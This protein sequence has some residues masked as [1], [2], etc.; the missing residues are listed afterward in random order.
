MHNH[1]SQQKSRLV[2]LGS[3]LLGASV[4]VLYAVIS[5]MNSYPLRSGRL[6]QQLITDNPAEWDE[7]QSWLGASRDFWFIFV[8]PAYGFAAGMLG[9]IVFLLLRKTRLRMCLPVLAT[10]GAILFTISLPASIH[11]YYTRGV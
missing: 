11:L 5:G 3:F 9:R 6:A 2:L 8:M 4:G 10:S 7:A 1:E